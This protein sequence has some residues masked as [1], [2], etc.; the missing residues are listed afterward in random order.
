MR[1]LPTLTAALTAAL[2]L[3]ATAAVGPT[4]T[5]AAA[6]DDGTTHVEQHLSG[7]AAATLAKLRQKLRPLATPEAA[8]AAG[9]LPSDECVA[10]PH[11]GMGYHY[12]NLDIF[13]TDP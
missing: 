8:V 4:V 11:G 7:Q 6:H 1:S 13:F 2:A 3:T 10:G 9:Y 5:A 12:V